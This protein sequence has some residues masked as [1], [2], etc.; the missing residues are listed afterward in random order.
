MD[1]GSIRRVI[2]GTAGHIDHGKSSVVRALTGIDPDRLEEERARGMTIDLGFARYEHGS[3]ALVGIIDVPGH[4][5]FIK[6]MVAGAT[7]V[8]I[9]AL[10]VAA[11]DG[12]MPQTREH[13]DILRLLGVE[14]GLVV[15]TKIDLVEPELLELARDDIAEFVAGTFL[16]GAPVVSVSSQTG[17]GMDAL[18]ATLDAL[19]DDVPTRETGGPFRLPVQRVFSAAGH[20]TVATGVPVAGEVGVGDTLELVGAGKEARVRGLQ[21]YGRACDAARAGHSVA[22]N[23]TGLGRD[24]ITRGDVLATP[25]VFVARRHLLAHYRH[26]DAAGPAAHNT[27]VRVH[28]GTAEVIG[29]L[30]VLDGDEVARGEEAFVQ[31]RLDAPLVVAPGDRVLV[32]HAASMTLLG[33]GTALAT[34][35]GRVKRF[36]DRV[37]DDARRRLAAGDDPR[38]WLRAALS[39]AGRRGATRDDLA[40]DVS[41]TP[42][43]LGALVD[44]AL[45]AGDA[46]RAGELTFEPEAIE[47]IAGEVVGA[48]RAEHRRLPLM[49]WLDVRTLRAA[50]DVDDAVLAAVLEHDD[51]FDVAAGGRVRR[52]GH[53]VQLA[54]E[55]RAAREAIL[56]AADAAPASPPKSSA[57][58]LGLDDAAL[59]KLLDAMRASG[60]LVAIGGHDFSAAGLASLREHLLDHARQRDGA[61]DIPALRDELDTSRKYLIPLLEHFDA[62][63]LTLREGDGRRIRPRHLAD[64]ATS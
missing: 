32:R 40:H 63:G 53:R 57:A 9:V 50:V 34:T 25:G 49:E 52:R 26:V 51:R 21:A 24:E 4:E 10:I 8:D 37:L 5:R 3:G 27:P 22:L 6:N 60:E 31:L 55:L 48:L 7:S 33:G 59:T 44:E 42:A 61:I 1:E 15:V 19:V 56:A 28:A 2:V 20:G 35:D 45:E 17:E 29:R 30:V 62:D 58:D 14:R 11:D 46:V 23:V 39:S 36:K 54:P 47:E 38:G 16:E 41:L 12:V 64:E 43:A 13:L 18:R